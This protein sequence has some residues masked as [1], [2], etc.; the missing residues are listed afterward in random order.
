MLSV[1]PRLCAR[2]WRGVVPSERTTPLPRAGITVTRTQGVY[3]LTD[4]LIGEGMYGVGAPLQCSAFALHDRNTRLGGSMPQP[5]GDAA[6][7]ACIVVMFKRFHSRRRS[8]ERGENAS[9]VRFSLVRC[10]ASTIFFETILGVLSPRE[11]S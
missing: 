4:V 5:R 7:L 6:V 11:F 1:W 9:T 3:G 10:R 2:L 8:L